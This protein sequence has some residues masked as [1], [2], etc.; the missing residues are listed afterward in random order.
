MPDADR[1]VSTW[2]RQVGLIPLLYR[3]QGSALVTLGF[4]IGDVGACLFPLWLCIDWV[5]NLDQ[6]TEVFMKAKLK[7]GVDVLAVLWGQVGEQTRHRQEGEWNPNVI[8]K[9]PHGA[10]RVRSPHTS[11]PWPTQ[12][13]GNMACRRCRPRESIRRDCRPGSPSETRART[14]QVRGGPDAKADAAQSPLFWLKS[15]AF[16]DITLERL[17]IGTFAPA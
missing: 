1:S 3:I 15:I 14:G 10:V 12:R 2:R 17:E 8:P 16:L 9:G 6:R 4:T 13:A 5:S 7:T 11:F